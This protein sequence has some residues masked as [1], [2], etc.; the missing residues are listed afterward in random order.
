VQFVKPKHVIPAH[1]EVEMSNAL[2]EL[3]LEM[4][5]KRDE[6]VHVIENGKSLSL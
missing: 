3:V 2:L 1:G 4:G 6:N 5:Y